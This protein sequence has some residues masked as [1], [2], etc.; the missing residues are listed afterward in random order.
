MDNVCVA[1]K[2]GADRF[3]T[4]LLKLRGCKCEEQ[5]FSSTLLSSK[6]IVQCGWVGAG[7]EKPSLLRS[8]DT[9]EK[10]FKYL[11]KIFVG[12]IRQW[13]WRPMQTYRTLHTLDTAC[14]HFNRLLATACLFFSFHLFLRLKFKVG[15]GGGAA[16]RPGTLPLTRCHLG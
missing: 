10:R 12:V 1:A 3:C 15:L 5:R 11:C 13:Q 6:Q 8:C 2:G 16:T 14:M 9:L 4:T 7:E